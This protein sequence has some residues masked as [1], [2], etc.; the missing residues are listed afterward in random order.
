MNIYNKD[1]LIKPFMKTIIRSLIIG[2]IKNNIKDTNRPTIKGT[3]YRALLKIPL[4][5]LL[6]THIIGT[7]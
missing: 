5:A 7:I 4:G 6:K 2:P 1:L 3:H